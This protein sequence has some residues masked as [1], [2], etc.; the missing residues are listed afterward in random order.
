MTARRSLPRGLAPACATAL[1]LLAAAAP[2]HAQFGIE[3]GTF[4]VRTTDAAGDELTQAGGHPNHTTDFTVRTRVDSRGFTV[5][6]GTLKDVRVELPPGFVGDPEAMPK[7]DLADVNSPGQSTCPPNTQVGV[8]DIVQKLTPNDPVTFTSHVPVYNAV[9]PRGQTAAFAF[10]FAR[11]TVIIDPQVRTEGDK[12]VT[13][14]VRNVPA[15]IIVYS[16]SLTLWGVPADPANDPDR[17]DP[18]TGLFGASAGIEPRPF[19]TNPFTC[20]VVPTTRI[21][22]R[23]WEEPDR[24]VPAGESTTSATTGC[25][26]LTFEPSLDVA[27]SSSA[28]DSPTGLTV[29]LATPQND[30]PQGVS[31]PPLRTAE[32]TLPEGMSINPSSASGL[33]ACADAQLG[34]DRRDPVACPDAS[35]IGTATAESPVLDGPLTGSV[36]VL[37]Q[38]SDDPASGKMFRLALVL[39]NVERGLLFKLPGSVRADPGTGRLVATFEDNPQ[40]P[41]ERISVSLKA[42]PRAPLALPQDCGPRTVE[43]RISSWGGQVANLADTIA[44]D[45]Q[46][47]PGFA[48]GFRAGALYPAGGRFSPFVARLERPDG[49]RFLDGVTVELPTGIAARLR[50]V[51]LC[52]DAGMNAGACPAGSRVGTA[53]VGAGAGPDPFYLGGQ[54]VYLG[55]PYKGAP[56]SLSVVT[57]AIAGP[58]DLGTVV[59]RQ[60]LHVDRSDAHVTAVSDPLPT[61]VKGV[62]LRLRS[63]NVELDRPGFVVN[64]T[65]CAP[66][67]VGATI[68]SVGGA[69]VARDT[70]FQAADCA[71]LGFKPRLAL[72]LTGRSQTRTGRHPGLRAGLTQRVAGASA[73][74]RAVVRLPRSLALDPDNAQALCEF[75]DGSRDDLERHCPKGSIVGRARA[76]TPLLERDLTGDVYFVKNVRVDRRTGNAI[77]TL[78]KLVVALR[79]EIDI[80]LVGTSSTAKDGRLVSTFATAP[81][82]PVSRFGLVLRGGRNG[83]LTVTRTRA[84][85]IDLCEKPRGQLAGVDLAGHNG[86]R[87]DRTV[88]VATPCATRKARRG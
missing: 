81:D 78:P 72:R 38:A 84:G 77:R 30:D 86:K 6:A 34:A 64:P 46:G 80:N 2:A 68:R 28:P 20:G 29:D 52:S 36:H 65:S 31:T 13:A 32:V 10:R 85:R 53:T 40:L 33:E 37:S 83:I 15:G 25:D 63:V 69:Q 57:R 76:R 9:T 73:M 43:A 59:V 67:A 19:L 22:L 16:Q 11:D 60:A 55:G 71:R 23:S 87:V 58:Y 7:C 48:P 82:A 39:E 75:D 50:G 51:P 41:V 79:G 44:V 3:P 24:W 35:K 66:K 14:V 5:P 42:G 26:Q 21:W 49:Q 1:A 27:A 62:P 88:R 56:Y 8:I 4:Q 61:I 18:M 74:R 70:R 47:G 54:P 12:G 45:C 17:Y